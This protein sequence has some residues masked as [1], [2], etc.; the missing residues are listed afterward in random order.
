[1][2]S[3]RCDFLGEVL[4]I[5]VMS[6]LV[7]CALCPRFRDRCEIDNALSTD[8]IFL[9]I[10]TTGGWEACSYVFCMTNLTIDHASFSR[11]STVPTPDRVTSNIWGFGIGD[12]G[13]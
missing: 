5:R 7:S 13:E 11:R 1:M 12:C 10:V 3:R 8:G 4:S 6:Q 9:D 2:H